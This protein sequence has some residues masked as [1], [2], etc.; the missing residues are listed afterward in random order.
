MGH[1]QALALLVVRRM[2]GGDG[3]DGAV[4]QAFDDGGAVDLAA[5]RR[6][7]FGEGAVIA[8]IEV[9]EGKMM[10]RR[11]AG[12]PQPARLGLA[13]AV[14]GIG[15]RDMGDVIA[16]AG[17]LDQ[18]D[19]ALDHHGLGD[20]GNTF[21]A[22]TGGDLALGHAAAGGQRKILG[23]LRDQEIECFG[24]AQRAA[25]HLAIG[26]RQPIIG[27]R[28]RAGLG[29]HA[30]FG[31]LLAFQPFGDGGKRE[32][33]DALGFARAAV[34]EFDQPDIVDH[35]VG[36]GHAAQTGHT[37]GQCREAAGGDG[38]LMFVAGLA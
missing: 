7:H 25:H 15:G 30:E 14:H 33:L 10:R 32:H 16:P 9:G 26:N 8:D 1:R 38:F 21:E 27:E 31:Q 22:E 18:A 3:V 5:Q 37:A 35:R 24:V 2:I 20:F 29:Q 4:L 19:I 12:D 6:R 34:D 23:M 11:L 13:H 36:V 17:M 28:H